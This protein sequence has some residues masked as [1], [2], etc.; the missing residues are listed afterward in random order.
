MLQVIKTSTTKIL[1]H[2]SWLEAPEEVVLMVLRIQSMR[3]SEPL[4]FAQLLNW[5]RAQVKDE[6]DVRAKINKGLKLIHFCA[7]D[8]TEFSRL[9]RKP[10]PLTADEMCKI[11]LSITQKN[12]KFLPEGFSK[13]KTPR[14]LGRTL[15][16]DWR[17]LESD[18]STI[19][20]SLTDPVVLNVAVETQYYLIGILLHSL[21]NIN[22]GELVHLTCGIYSSEYPTLRITTATFNGIVHAEESDGDLDFPQ[23]V[24][25]KKGIWYKIKVSYKHTSDRPAAVFLTDQS[26]T[27]KHSD[28][29]N[30]EGKETTVIF[31]LNGE[32]TAPTIDI[33]G[34]SMAK[35]LV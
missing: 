24:L 5:G 25:M 31:A 10:V 17:S 2:K 20:N 13:V 30:V 7:M 28:P 14:C 26:Y 6:A 19:V 22:A 8:Y 4:L 18:D 35:N 33:R 32:S 1:L 11:F 21:T 16:Y 34:L 23:P 12:S 3:I 15:L 29:N 27:W 9:C